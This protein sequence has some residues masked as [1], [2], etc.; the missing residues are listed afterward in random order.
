MLS[1]TPVPTES[2]DSPDST[3]FAGLGLPEPVLER[4]ARLGFENPTEIQAAAIPAL[5][6]GRDLVGVAQ[7]GT[8]KTA[9][10]GLPLLARLQA[11]VEG[12]QA[13][14]LTPTRELALQVSEAL[15]TMAPLR[16]RVLAIYGG[17]PFGPQLRQL[18][19]GVDVVVGTPGRVIDLI[20]RG[21]LDTS[22]VQTLVLDE[23]DE[24]LRMGF[25]E[26][27]ATIL[28]GT[29]PTRQTALFSATMPREIRK[30]AHT[31][32]S[33]PV[34]VSMTPSE[35]TTAS[36]NQTY[37]VV[38]MR[39]KTGA[40]IRV[41]ATTDAEATIVFV[42]TRQIAEDLGAELVSR[43]V[44]AATISGD[45]AQAERE[46]IVGRLRSGNLNVLVATDVA[47]RGLD[48]DRIGLVV[49]YDVPRETEAYVHRIGRTGRAGRTGT[50]LMFLTP[51]ERYRL[52][53]IERATRSTVTEVT[54]PT[55]AEV[56]AHRADALLAQLPDRLER[57]RLDLYRE[58]VSI[59]LAQ[60]G[61]DPLDV[62]AALVALGVGDDGPQPRGREGDELRP[63]ETTFD[64]A[65]P[66]RAARRAANERGDGDRGGYRSHKQH[67]PSRGEHGRGG[68]PGTVY[69]VDVGRHHGV[70][71][72]AIV[73]A[74][75]GEGGLR[76]SDVGKI[77][78]FSSFSLVEISAPL[79][80]ESSRRIGTA[81][82]AG[83]RL[84]I[85]PD[86]GRPGRPER[87]HSGPRR[88]RD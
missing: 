17:A 25:A 22:T 74:L 18:T 66:A 39:H 1:E 65:P 48:V 68:G 38:P 4:I 3:T 54:I 43:G 51:K 75:T 5:L 33:D 27:V 57:G 37:A 78:I 53:S 12:L 13:L 31:H 64:D 59:M 9:A 42:R 63:H 2:T 26:E 76:G 20:N 60:S 34:E 30:V 16:T 79:S 72:N 80:P 86:N 77:E 71:P 50:A 56:S 21:A 7:T 69:R 62:A 70:R 84:Q 40:L 32:M 45:V 35:P 73:G 81:R 88:P 49:N 47:A 85:R 8:G 6:Q 11:G 61:R 58:R 15:R 24:M 52:N 28:E 44:N 55:P 29:P 14:V 10:F 87:R 67:S 36:I 82:V 23:A 83:Q 41:L 19:D 46:R